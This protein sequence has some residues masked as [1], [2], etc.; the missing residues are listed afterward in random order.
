[1]AP[2]F[3][4]GLVLSPHNTKLSPHKIFTHVIQPLRD[5]TQ[6]LFLCSLHQALITERRQRS[7][8]VPAARFSDG[9]RSDTLMD[10]DTH[11]A[12]LHALT[13][14]EQE[15]RHHGYVLK[16][17]SADELDLKRRCKQ[18]GQRIRRPLRHASSSNEESRENMAS[19]LPPAASRPLASTR[20]SKQAVTAAGNVAEHSSGRK[21]WAK[22]CQ[23]H[24]GRLIRYVS[25]SWMGV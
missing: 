16:R 3:F 24:P 4:S 12:R 13:H 20:R 6:V 17:L 18:C 2:A 15:L 9:S 21:N 14:T 7:L 10:Y 5:S 1:M 23:Y 25:T 22:P 8:G 11:L 19:S